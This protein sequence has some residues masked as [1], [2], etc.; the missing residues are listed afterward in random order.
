MFAAVLADFFGEGGILMKKLRKRES[1]END[2][3][4]TYASCSTSCPSC[5]AG[6]RC[7]SPPTEAMRSAG[8]EYNRVLGSENVRAYYGG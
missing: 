5:G 4:M 2:S 3:V 8:I 1:N 6:N 7:D